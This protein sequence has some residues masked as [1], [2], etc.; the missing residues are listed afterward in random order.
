MSAT[1]FAAAR[2]GATDDSS[3]TGLLVGNISYTYSSEQAFAKNHLG[4]DVG[5]SLY[6]ESTE[7]SISGV[8]KTKATGLVPDIAAV[9]TLANSSA[10]TLAADSKNLF[11]TPTAGAGVLVTGAT[12]N[13]V[14]SEF[15]N[16]EVSAIYKP[17]ISLSS[18]AVL[19]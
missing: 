18:P 17:L 10:D 19:T 8:V 9:L 13:R 4:S 6:N 16:G 5:A 11:T 2:Y 1:V 14:N 3:A 15:E 12:L 7:I